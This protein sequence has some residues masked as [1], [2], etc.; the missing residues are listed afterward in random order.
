MIVDVGGQMLQALGYTVLTA[1]SGNDAVKVYRENRESIDIVVLDLMMPGM[2]GG[3][4][5]DK[6]KEIDP[7]VKVVLSSGYGLDGAASEVMDRGCIGFIQK[8]FNLSGL[9]RK[10]KDVME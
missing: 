10:I 5:F 2:S 6:L 4:T 3:A 7:G 9:S 1:C 8:P